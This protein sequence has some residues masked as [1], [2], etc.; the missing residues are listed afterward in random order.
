[1]ELDLQGKN[2]LV[3]G[4]G[5]G[6]GRAIAVALASHGTFVYVNYRSNEVGA[7]ETLS[8]LE[9]GGGK[10]RVIAADVS[11]SLEVKQ[12]FGKIAES[13]GDL[14]I[15]VNNAGG[16]VKRAKIAE[17]SDELWDEVMG[18][19]VK[20]TFLCC[21]AVLPMLQR[22]GWGRIVNISSLAAHDGGG[23]GAAHYAAAKG[24]ITTFTKGLAKEA[25]PYGI[26]V[27][28]VAP[29]LINTAFH[30]VHTA[31]TARARMV[32][33]T[34]LAREGQPDD[35]ADGV[36]FLVSELARFITGELLN[37][38]GGQRMA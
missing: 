19:N 7:H 29:G 27:N 34:P 18:I 16:L 26:T 6:I 8:L 22:A 15:L 35:V 33:N 21:R 5:S 14:N 28:A 38:N 36:L 10:G 17:M 31:D 3:T 1:M 11:Q 25:A 32:E 4:A 30:D 12:L 20:S 24:A 13:S 23:L 37:I 9:Q 2:A